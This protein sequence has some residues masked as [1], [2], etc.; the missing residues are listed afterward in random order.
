MLFSKGSLLHNSRGENGFHLCSYYQDQ[1]SWRCARRY[2]FNR[3]NHFP[4]AG[5]TSCA[6]ISSPRCFE[7]RARIRIRAERKRG[8][9][10]KRRRG[11]SDHQEWN[12]FF[13]D[14]QRNLVHGI[15]TWRRNPDHFHRQGSGMHENQL[16]RS[17]L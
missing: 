11:S 12:T 15:Q 1:H 2:Q 9:G 10:C 5:S 4:C 17:R 3:E 8:S 16:E 6:D 14:Q 13:R 7:K